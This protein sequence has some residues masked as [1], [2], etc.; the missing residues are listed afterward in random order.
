MSVI[1]KSKKTKYNSR[2]IAVDGISFDSAKEA[3]RYNELK[4]LQ[5]AGEISGLELQKKFVL[6]P[7]QREV[8]GTKK[9]GQPITKCI[10]R[11]CA[12]IADFCYLDH[13]K[14]YHVED[15]KGY[16]KSKAYDVFVIKR[17]LMLYVHG[18]KIE[19]V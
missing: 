15:V 10:E 12:Y 18:I 3:R 2:K 5:D 7:A 16:K 9:N 6:I 13:E 8:I 17:K 1:T 19:E 4:L 11:E 14:R